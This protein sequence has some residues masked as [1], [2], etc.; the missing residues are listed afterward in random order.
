MDKRNMNIDR[1]KFIAI[2]MVLLVHSSTD[3]FHNIRY[4]STFKLLGLSVIHIMTS[5]AVPLFLMASGYF[6]LREKKSYKEMIMDKILS[7]WIVFVILLIFY[8]LIDYVQYG[9]F[10]VGDL[11]LESIFLKPQ[12]RTYLWYIPLIIGLYLLTPLLSELVQLIDIK[13]H[14]YFLIFVFVLS[15][16]RN[17]N[18][19]MQAMGWGMVSDSLK[20][21]SDELIYIAYFTFGYF[22]YKHK[23]KFKIPKYSWIVVSIIYLPIRMFLFKRGIAYDYASKPTTFI[24]A[25]LMFDYIYNLEFESDFI[26]HIGTNTLYIYLFHREISTW[27]ANLIGVRNNFVVVIMV[28]G[29]SFVVSYILTQLYLGM[30]SCLLD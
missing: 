27:I 5:V 14:K 12:I 18:D 26:H 25:V 30:K 3:V 9:T 28:F 22:Y 7:L 13:T 1:I 10:N 11:L 8:H 21:P 6:L 15:L 17:L 20:I 19:F 16:Q 29:L 4:L 24:L 23:D 2:L